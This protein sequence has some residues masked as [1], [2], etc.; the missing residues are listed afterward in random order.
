[1][2]A[3]FINDKIWDCSMYYFFLIEWTTIFSI[4][5]KMSRPKYEGPPISVRTSIRP[6]VPSQL[7]AKP[8]T[9]T[10]LT[11]VRTDF[12]GQN[13]ASL[14]VRTSIST[15]FERSGILT[16][17]AEASRVRTNFPS[18]NLTASMVQTFNL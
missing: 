3:Y 12:P 11:C 13:P 16:Q 9:R 7:V 2:L 18:Q 1:M 5:M 6:A 14:K 8:K 10:F 17:E 4:Y 15:K